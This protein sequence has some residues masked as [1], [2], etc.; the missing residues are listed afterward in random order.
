M[1]RK[2]FN[3]GD[4]VRMKKKHPC[5]SYNWEVIRM[6]A[7]IKIK[8]MGCGRIVMLPRLKFEKNMQR[9]ENSCEG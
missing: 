4:I 9:V 2:L 1:E 3:L 6:G 8:C 5:G 7:D